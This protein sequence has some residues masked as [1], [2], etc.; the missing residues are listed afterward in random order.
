MLF[1]GAQSV[2]VLLLALLSLF[3]S[4]A[5]QQPDYEYGGDYSGDY[6][7]GDSYQDYTDPYTQPDNLYADYAKQKMEAEGAGGG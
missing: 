1:L 7:N 3:V 2:T 4:I 6:G 5:A